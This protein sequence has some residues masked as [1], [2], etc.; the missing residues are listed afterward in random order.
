V[1]FM[2]NNSILMKGDITDEMK[3]KVM[4]DRL[5]AEL[6]DEYD[7]RQYARVIDT[8]QDIHISRQVVTKN[9]EADEK[10]EELEEAQIS[11]E[12]YAHIDE[13]LYKNVAHIVL[14]S[15]SQLSADRNIW[16]DHVRGAAQALAKRE[17]EHLGD[18]IENV[19]ETAPQSNSW[20][21]D[22]NDP[23]KDLKQ[24]AKEIRKDK[25]NANVALMDSDAEADLLGNENIIDRLERGATAEDGVARLAGLRL[26]VSNT[27]PEEDVCY[28]M[29]TN[30][31]GVILADG[32]R[33][34]ETYSGDAS[35]FDGYAVADFILPTDVWSRYD[36][37]PILKIDTS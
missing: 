3:A 1:I 30:A 5:R 35:F 32:P 6:I 18:E 33:M 27:L 17:N 23:Y 7:L 15:E 19:S 13:T 22:S 11:R 16:N 10:V 21:D 36:P 34:V 37:E 28:V 26:A 9:V 4:M 29:D 12:A 8:G 2:A 20:D 14:S 31:P 24:A 25:L